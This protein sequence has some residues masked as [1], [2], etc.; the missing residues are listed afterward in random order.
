MPATMLCPDEGN[1]LL[2][3]HLG[4]TAKDTRGSPDPL[5]VVSSDLTQNAFSPKQAGQLTSPGGQSPG[6]EVL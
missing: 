4:R 3:Q 5:S 6:S 2:D 1:A